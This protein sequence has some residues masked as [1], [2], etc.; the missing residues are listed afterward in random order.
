LI[1]SEVIEAELRKMSNIDKLK[2]I[3][4]LLKIANFKVIL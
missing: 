1:N 4:D 2:Q 3:K